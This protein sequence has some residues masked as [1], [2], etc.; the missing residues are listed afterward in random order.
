MNPGGKHDPS[1]DTLQAGKVPTYDLRMITIEEN[2]Q[3]LIFETGKQL[4][5]ALANLEEPD[6]ERFAVVQAR[7]DYIDQLKA[8]I[9]ARCYRQ[10]QD[11]A[12]HSRKEL[13]RLI[14]RNVITANLE[15]IAD[16]AVNLCKQALYLHNPRLPRQYNYYEMFS[17]V[18]A[19]I[20]SIVPALKDLSVD[21]AMEI[22]TRE[23]VLDKIFTEYL[24]RITR[25]LQSGRQTRD[26]LTMLFILRYLERMGDCLLN[27]G[28]AIISAALGQRMKIHQIEALGAN[29]KA[30]GGEPPLE[31]LKLHGYRDTRS[32]C[33]ITRVEGLQGGL[34]SRSAIFKEGRIAKISREEANLRRWAEL[35]PGLVPRVYEYQPHEDKAS[36]LI[37]YFTGNTLQALLLGGAEEAGRAGVDALLN[38]L[39]DI[40]ERTLRPE[41]V[42]PRFLSQLKRRMGDVRRVHP[43]LGRY[44]QE[45]CGISVP[46]LGDLLGLLAEQDR[47]LSAPFSV[48]IHGDLNVDNLIY[49]PMTDSV[50]MIDVYRSEQ[51]D[52]LQDISVFI[53]SMYRLPVRDP[54]RRREIERRIRS[55]LAV[56]GVF[57][58]AHGDTGW[59]ARLGL[60]IARS[61]ISS[62]RFVLD[63]KLARQLFLLGVY[64]MES[65]LEW[66]G[67]AGEYHMPGELF[68]G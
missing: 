11:G 59:Q 47:S 35:A 57:A 37:E 48:W 67:P 9:E 14:A 60:G 15:R 6:P 62:T 2:F 46:S 55:V 56:T 65:L 19:G 16:Y 12:G 10:F 21:Q 24:D 54:A 53:V 58:A 41:P 61:C 26:L 51:Q 23:A 27:I 68:H 30:V 63:R 28:E 13:D 25:R 29:L 8:L 32:G 44:A 45:I 17:E 36:L 42:A 31:T 34:D 22:C 39:P 33:Q 66:D 64:L 50:H 43:W 52:Y 7:D 3:F 49:N 38:V 4:D 40:W 18:R 1:R 20:D 5:A